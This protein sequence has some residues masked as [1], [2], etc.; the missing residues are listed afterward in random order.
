L[1]DYKGVEILLISTDESLGE[2]G[3]DLEAEDRAAEKD[4]AEV[5]KALHM[6]QSAEKE[7]PLLRGLWQ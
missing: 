7:R 2:L 3:I 4:A 5:F 6:R 1:L